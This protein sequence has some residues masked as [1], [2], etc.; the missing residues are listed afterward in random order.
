MHSLRASVGKA[1]R[2]DFL[3]RKKPPGAYTPG[4]YKSGRDSDNRRATV[5]TVAYHYLTTTR[6]ASL[7]PFAKVFTTMFTPR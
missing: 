4:G 5:V 3:I 7:A 1:A 2:P 6:K